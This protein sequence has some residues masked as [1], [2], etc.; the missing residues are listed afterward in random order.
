MW[1]LRIATQVQAVVLILHIQNREDAAL[2]SVPNQANN[3]I[4]SWTPENNIPFRVTRYDF[5]NTAESKTQN[6]LGFFELKVGRHRSTRRTGNHSALLHVKDTTLFGQVIGIVQV[7][8]ID[9]P[10][11]ACHNHILVRWMELGG[12]HK[13]AIA[14]GWCCLLTRAP[15]PHWEPSVTA[16][17][18]ST[19]MLSAINFRKRQA[20]DWVREVFPIQSNHFERG[21]T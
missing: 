2:M 12:E 20:A 15:V 8:E 16:V 11:S 3:L 10:F 6:I 4:L 1:I 7:P 9:V 18:N 19:Q 13:I 21:Q 14:L 5:S 17:V